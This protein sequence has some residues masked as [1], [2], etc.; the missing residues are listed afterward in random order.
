MENV[1]DDGCAVFQTAAA[2]IV[3]VT[4]IDRIFFRIGTGN[5]S[6]LQ[7]VGQVVH[8]MQ[9]SAPVFPDDLHGGIPHLFAQKTVSRNLQKLF[10]KTAGIV[11]RMQ[12]AG[13]CQQ[14]IRILEAEHVGTHQD[15]FCMGCRFQH[16]MPAVALCHAAAHKDHIAYGVNTAQ[17]TDSINQHHGTFR[18]G[19]FH[20]LQFGTKTGLVTE[21]AAQPSDFIYP[22][23]PA[24]SYDKS[25]FGI[26]SAQFGKSGEQKIFFRCMGG[27]CHDNRK[28]IVSQ[29]QFGFIV[30]QV[31]RCHFRISLVKFRIAG[32][33]NLLGIRAQMG[34]VIGINTGLHTETA[35]SSQHV[36]PDTEQILVCLDRSFRNTAVN[37]HYGNVPFPDRPQKVRP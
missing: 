1:L 28:R 30:C 37:H 29:S 23:S 21:P 8:G 25:C 19:F 3:K 9:G 6:F 27:T 20:I 31:F 2:C 7:Q 26:L 36:T 22:V 35:Y 34:N 33:K 13:L 18:T 10:R 5:R 14:R 11:Y 32:Y 16:V 12:S 17:F 24:G 15:G 4:G